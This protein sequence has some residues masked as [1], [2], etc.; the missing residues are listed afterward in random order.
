MRFH[1]SFDDFVKVATAVTI[2]DLV[3]TGWYRE[4]G[5]DGDEDLAVE[6]DDERETVW[7]NKR[8]CDKAVWDPE[9]SCYMVKSVDDTIYRLRFFISSLLI[10]MVKA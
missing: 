3:A 6:V 4:N 10:P 2:D 8:E 7:F 5:R 9:R 1:D